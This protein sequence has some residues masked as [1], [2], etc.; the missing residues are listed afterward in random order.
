[1]PEPKARRATGTPKAS[2]DAGTPTEQTSTNGALGILATPPQSQAAP[3]DTFLTRLMMLVGQYLDLDARGLMAPAF[4][5]DSSPVIVPAALANQLGPREVVAAQAIISAADEWARAVRGER[6]NPR[7]RAGAKGPSYIAPDRASLPFI[8]VFNS[9]LQNI[10]ENELLC[11]NLLQRVEADESTSQDAWNQAISAWDQMQ[12]YAEK[13]ANATDPTTQLDLANSGIGWSHLLTALNQTAVNAAQDAAAAD[14]T[15]RSLK[16]GQIVEIDAATTAAQ[17]YSDQLTQLVNS[18]GTVLILLVLAIAQAEAQQKLDQIQPVLGQ[19]EQGLTGPGGVAQCITTTGTW[20]GFECTLD[21]D[22]STKFESWLDKN[23]PGLNISD[24]VSATAAIIVGQTAGLVGAFLKL[25]WGAVLEDG[26]MARV[27]MGHVDKGAGVTFHFSWIP[28]FVV[29]VLG[30]YTSGGN[31][32]LA[33][34]EIF[35]VVSGEL[36]LEDWL[37][38]SLLNPWTDI[39]WITGN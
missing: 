25:M 29:G 24:V 16:C 30:T 26:H 22:C 12:L 34:E 21:E 35:G 31:W 23:S 3:G 7:P 6:P 1:M 5:L 17:Q 27:I 4:G 38:T 33:L 36:A 18:F 8:G 39:I 28:S 20:Y 15:A 11:Q 19:V 13:A 10:L 37:G 2:M 14:A 9:S 32:V